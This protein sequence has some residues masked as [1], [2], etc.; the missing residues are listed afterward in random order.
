[1]DILFR[2]SAWREDLEFILTGDDVTEEP[3]PSI[4][5]LQI[6]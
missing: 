3:D 5:W 4:G 1:M 6:D 2:D